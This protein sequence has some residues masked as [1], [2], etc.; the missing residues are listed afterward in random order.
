MAQDSRIGATLAGYRIERLLGR[1]GMGRVYLAEDTRLGRK[2][3]LKLL[4]P[5]LAED[6]RFRER[7][8]RESRLA[9]S[10]DHPNVIPIYEAGEGDGVLFIAMRYVEGT[11][12]ARLIEEEGSLQPG[13]TAAIVSQVADALDAAHERGLIHR[14]VK[15]GNILVGRGDHIYL[16]DFGLIKRRESDPGLT[17]TGQFMGSVDYAAPEQIRGEAVDPRTDVYSLGCVLYECLV[18]EP[19]YAHDPE[20]AVL[21]A[22]LNDPPPKVTARH[23]ELAHAV[24]A[25]VE[26]AMAKRPDDRYESAG[27]MAQAAR[28][29]I[30]A[31]APGGGPTPRLP[32]KK[33]VVGAGVTVLVVALAVVLVVALTRD[34]GRPSAA[35]SHPASTV[36]PPP[37]NSLVEIDAATGRVVRTIPNVDG[38]RG[39]AVGEGGVWALLPAQQQASFLL[40][41]DAST[42]KRHGMIGN[43]WRMAVGAHGV[44]V[45]AFSGAEG[46][47]VLTVRRVDAATDEVIGRIPR[48]AGAAG[49]TQ[50]GARLSIGEGGVWAVFEDGTVE[51]ID[52]RSNTVAARTDTGLALDGVAAG[53]GAVWA[54]DSFDEKVVRIDPATAQVTKTIGVQGNLTGIA[55]GL[56]RVWILDAVAGTVTTIDPGTGLVGTKFQVGSSPR[57]IA[58]GAGFVWVTDADGNLYR[59]DPVTLDV[60]KIPVGPSLALVAVDDASGKVWVSVGSGS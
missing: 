42:G 4:D 16:T 39:L 2:V 3:A 41:L 8:V 17:R 48:S 37:A 23:P 13:R 26:K 24:D 55:A 52:P 45:L 51:R 15:P 50:E 36:A 11:D 32:P 49:A 14:D 10:I 53:E 18:G 30:A 35:P 5:D 46:S 22:H 54:K 27:Q 29:A 33:V 34:G 1:G 38:T 7:F 44:W 58:V 20:I 28:D 40:H 47:G 59:V 25:V 31:P 21:Y 60:S 6:E 12:L 43:V 56:G 19:P 9:A 57:A